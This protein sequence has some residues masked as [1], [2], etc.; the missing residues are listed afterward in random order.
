VIGVHP[1]ALWGHGRGPARRLAPNALL[2][3]WLAAIGTCVVARPSVP[4]EL[5][6][7]AGLCA[8]WLLAC[9]PALRVLVRVLLLGLIL[10]L[11]FFLLLPWTGQ[12]AGQTELGPLTL[13]DDAWVAPWHVLVR[14]V[15]CLFLG[16]GLVSALDEAGFQEALGRLPMPRS[17]RVMVHQI[18]RSLE[19]LLTE[20]VGM[21]RAVAVRSGRAGWQTGLM[22][23]RALP[24]VWLPRVLLR[25]DR[26][27]RAMQVRGYAGELLEP[28]QRSWS[29][30][31]VLAILSSLAALALAVGLRWTS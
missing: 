16:L 12:G 7:I 17:L 28:R 22:L 13:R 23:A 24:S 11:P 10:F 31:E 30:R 19:P 5:G 15:A 29:G 4:A 9:G 20:S 2:L 6:L 21:G 1:S 14:G 26:V 3:C 8:V 25:A 27:T 18:F